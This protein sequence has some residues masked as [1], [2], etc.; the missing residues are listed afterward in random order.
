MIQCQ[1]LQTYT[2]RI[3]W[4]TVRRII[5]EILGVKGLCS[6]LV[7]RL[8]LTF[9]G[10]KNRFLF[11]LTKLKLNIQRNVSIKKFMKSLK[12]PE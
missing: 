2:M 3:V 9:R 5:N 7:L 6:H 10:R 4:Q 1:I 12:A 11:Y 8:L